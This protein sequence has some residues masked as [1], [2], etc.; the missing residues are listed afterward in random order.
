M[1]G[2]NATEKNEGL[3]A[4]VKAFWESCGETAPAGTELERATAIFVG[5]LATGKRIPRQ[6]DKTL[7]PLYGPRRDLE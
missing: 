7:Q 2:Q 3:Q 4:A 6:T 5:A 1:S